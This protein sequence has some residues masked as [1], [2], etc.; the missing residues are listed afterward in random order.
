MA[1]AIDQHAPQIVEQARV[2]RHLQ[3]VERQAD[4]VELARLCGIL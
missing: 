2:G 3:D 4:E 1:A